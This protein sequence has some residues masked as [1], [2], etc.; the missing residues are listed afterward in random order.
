MRI[1]RGTG[2]AVEARSRLFR[3][4]GA[5]LFIAVITVVGLFV[6]E[7]INHVYFPGL[8]WYDTDVL[9]IFFGGAL[10]TLA[11]LI[12]L[13][14]FEGLY[15]KIRR[16]NDERK[17]AEKALVKSKAIL[18]RAQVIAH[19]GNWA[20]NLKT[21]A[22]TWS[23]EIFKIFGYL[24]GEFQ[25]T[26]DWL[27]SKVV[28]DDRPLLTAA[29]DAAVREDRLFNLDYRVQAPDSSIRHINM[30]ADRIK[31]DR[32][33]NPEWMYGITQDITRR[34]RIE[35]ELQLAKSQAELYIDVMGHDI[36]N[37]NQI[38]MGYLEMAYDRIDSAGRLEKADAGLLEKPID[39]MK[40][41]A[42]LIGNV[43]KLQR[44]KSGDYPSR[45][46][47]LEPV[48]K[49]V[50]ARY[51]TVPGRDVRIN[52]RQA[53]HCRVQANDLIT[54]LYANIVGNAIKHSRGPLQIDVGIDKVREDGR[55]YCRVIIEDTGPGINDEMK[56][57]LTTRACM[58]GSRYTG[59]GLGL[60]LV[61]MLVDDF[62]GKLRIEDRVPE[63]HEKGARFV[64][65]L[66]SI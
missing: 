44:E 36:N 29:L 9:T 40:N 21:N 3:L 54:D 39:A 37:M 53:E 48:L 61:R 5:L 38:A 15:G 24:P 7:R 66:P 65:M 14:S 57:L 18:S 41:I 63:R 45:P 34:K 46:F 52:F 55:D 23:D 4:L 60:C 31:R 10:V 64:V 28:P 32:A 58:T 26:Y 11:A 42:R 17:Q 22:M 59:K 56:T 20:W 43:K 12:V 35:Q 49:D 6:T 2:D 16:E 27:L 13:L 8:S 50:I 33:G 1:F 19:I 62:H 47:D 25:P 30:V 51:V